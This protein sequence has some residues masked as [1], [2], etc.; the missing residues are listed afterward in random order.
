M[1]CN[2]DAGLISEL[3]SLDVNFDCAS[4]SE[5]KDVLEKGIPA[6]RIVFSNPIKSASAIRFAG[7]NGVETLV[8]DNFEELCKIQHH[9]PGANLLLRIVADDPTAAIKLDSKFGATV[10]EAQDLLEA[11]AA[12]NMTCIGICFHIGTFRADYMAFFLTSSQGTGSRDP[13]AFTRAIENAGK[14]LDFAVTLGHPVKVLDVG[15]GFTGTN[16]AKSASAIRNAA[17]DLAHR[18]PSVDIIAEP[19]RLF[20][21]SIFSLAVQVIGQRQ[22]PASKGGVPTARL[23]LN[24]GVYGNFMAT[25]LEHEVYK[26]AM[27]LHKGTAVN[28]QSCKGRFAYS[29]WGP[30]CDSLDLVADTVLMSHEVEVGDWLIFQNMGAYTSAC[31][32]EFN[33]FCNSGNTFYLRLGVPRPDEAPAEEQAIAGQPSSRSRIIDVITDYYRFLTRLPHIDPSDLVFPPEPEGWQTINEVELRARG[34]TDET[35]EILRRLPY[36]RNPD[37]P[38]RTAHNITNDSLSIAYCDGE[39]EPAWVH[40]QQPTPGH[41]IWLTTQTNKEGHYLLLDTKLGTITTWNPIYPGPPLPDSILDEDSLELQDRWMNYATLPVGDFFDICRRRYEKLI[42]IP[43]PGLK[44]N[45]SRGTAHHLARIMTRGFEDDYLY[46]DDEYDMSEDESSDGSSSEDAV[47]D[48][49]GNISNIEIDQLMADAGADGQY[50]V[51]E[52]ANRPDPSPEAGVITAHRNEEEY[53]TDVAFEDVPAGM[54]QMWQDTKDTYYI[55]KRNGWPADDY[56][57]ERF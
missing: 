35:I 17:N 41:I 46:S 26:P 33:G 29:L 56:D 24:D 13:T 54:K 52:L 45:N 6:K 11:A 2:P 30:T 9:A 55:Y 31:R 20:T 3:A 21:E 42:W 32:T 16:F 40:D 14:L 23:Y 51:E 43:V 15:G 1:K 37:L 10:E 34:R 38:I 27:I 39:L 25:I 49:E 7:E 57:R 4:I 48:D 5:M 36:L 22:T 47:D 8:F 12:M 50:A 19:G 18:H 44:D 28:V 53:E